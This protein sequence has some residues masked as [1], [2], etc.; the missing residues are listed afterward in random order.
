MVVPA[1]RPTQV[2]ALSS[3]L[4]LFTDD[5]VAEMQ[6]PGMASNTSLAEGLEQMANERRRFL[7]GCRD[8]EI[9][10]VPCCVVAPRRSP[11]LTAPQIRQEREPAPPG[12]GGR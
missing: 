5:K 1:A 9:T 10:C 11:P 6:R 4:L 7:N 8:L 12:G 2:D 3:Q